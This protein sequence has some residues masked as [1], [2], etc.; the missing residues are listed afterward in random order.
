MLIQQASRRAERKQ[1]HPTNL[2]IIDAVLQR[3]QRGRELPQDYQGPQHP[4][5]GENRIHFPHMVSVRFQQIATRV[6][7]IIAHPR[8]E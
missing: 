8:K 4:A 6:R 2:T 5:D 3:I 1:P 7:N